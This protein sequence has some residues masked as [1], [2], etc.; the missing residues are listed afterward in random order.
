MANVKDS[1]D[2]KPEPEEPVKTYKEIFDD[3]DKDKDGEI[4]KEEFRKVVK[5][6]PSKK[7]SID[8]VFDDLDTDKRGKIT[9]EQFKKM[10]NV[11]DSLDFKPEPEEPVKTY[12]EIFDD[13]DKD[14]DGEINKEEF[15]KVVKKRPSKKKSID[16]IF[17]DLDTDKKGKITKEQLEKIADIK[18]KVPVKAR[19]LSKKPNGYN[20]IFKELDKDKDGLVNKQE[21]RELVNHGPLPSKSEYDKIKKRDKLYQMRKQ[22]KLDDE[23]KGILTTITNIFDDDKEIQ[24]ENYGPITTDDVDDIDRIIRK[25]N[26]MNEDYHELIDEYYEFK[27]SSSSKGDRNIKLLVNKEKEIKELKEII[28]AM[29]QTTNKL[30]NSCEKKIVAGKLVKSDQLGDEDLKSREAFEYFKGQVDKEFSF[31]NK[32]CSER[33]KDLKEVSGKKKETVKE[34]IRDEV[35]EEFRKI[36]KKEVRK[37]IKEKSKP[38][39]TIKKKKGKNKIRTPRKGRK[40]LGSKRRRR[41]K[42]RRRTRKKK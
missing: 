29:K 42:S 22:K 25:Y 13:L 6:R 2:F 17:D 7:K 38:T 10:A 24:D 18:D 28:M 15:R 16:E 5:K 4:N 27:K 14:K 20:K 33:V 39:K 34:E 30:K 12:K 35:E 26:T 37:E 32:K 3:L 19:D 11:E 1:L 21:F 9:K 8:E 41:T 31:Q 36:L 40:S 23:N